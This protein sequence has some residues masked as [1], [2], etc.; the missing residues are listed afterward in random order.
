[1]T[2]AEIAHLDRVPPRRSGRSGLHLPV[3]T[4]G[5]SRGPHRPAPN[6]KTLVRTAATIGITSFDITSPSHDRD[7]IFEAAGQ[8]LYP[9]RRRRAE[10]TVSARIGQGTY[11]R[12]LHG[13]G[14]RQQIL[15]GLDSLLQR[16]SLTYLDVL[17]AH[18]IDPATPLEET[19]GALADIVRQGKAHY[20][21]LSAVSPHTLL[22]AATLLTEYDT[23]A[24]A[25]QISYS[26]L[27]RYAEPDLMETCRAQQWGIIA[28]APLAHGAL[29]PQG[30]GFSAE[31]QALLRALDYIAA[32][33]NQSVEQLALSWTLRDRHITSSLVTTS[34]P[35]HLIQLHK[36]TQ[37][38]HFTATERA[39][40][41]ACCPAPAAWSPSGTVDDSQ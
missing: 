41:D 22:Q 16:S 34:D 29:S 15:S 32:T 39:A 9:W 6:L 13:Y 3:L 35:E 7:G 20:V 18:R 28:C 33:R 12:A 1:M 37:K 2:Q 11:P 19:V 21:G 24:A 14:S 40:I 30:G 8:A 23:P 38:T 36:A 5:L 25:C 26:L 10:L 27:D 4:L 17:Y 31:R